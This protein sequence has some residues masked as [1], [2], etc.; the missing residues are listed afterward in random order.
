MSSFMPTTPAGSYS[1]LPKIP[2]A[3]G[4]GTLQNSAPM[5][6]VSPYG[7][8]GNPTQQLDFGTGFGADPSSFNLKTDADGFSPDTG[9][10]DKK[11]GWVGKAGLA[12]GAVNA[13]IGIWGALEQSKM[14]DFMRS[15]YGDHIAIQRADFAN[16]AKST[17]EALTSKR[18]RVLSAQGTTTG[19]DANKAG[20]ADYMNQWGMQESV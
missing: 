17:N 8:V 13:G 1:F 20:V 14:N 3:S 11:G 12:L 19:T 9:L 18:E 2:G 6:G 16:A 7:T 4:P 15:Y 5:P 10:P